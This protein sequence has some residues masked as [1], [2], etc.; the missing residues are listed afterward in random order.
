MYVYQQI[1]A[2]AIIG[3][4][5]GTFTLTTA[6]YGYLQ[7]QIKAEGYSNGSYSECRL[8]CIILFIH[9]LILRGT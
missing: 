6:V 2:F 1:L 5:M 9:E 7:T 8:C 4:N 3:T